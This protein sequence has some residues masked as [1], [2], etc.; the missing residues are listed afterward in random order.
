M[1]KVEGA[2]SVEYETWATRLQR[3]RSSVAT[4]RIAQGRCEPCKDMD[5]GFAPRMLRV[6]M[7]EN[8]INWI[9]LKQI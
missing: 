9:K 8:Y 3:V 2:T 1:L 6:L 7:L 4:N 5:D